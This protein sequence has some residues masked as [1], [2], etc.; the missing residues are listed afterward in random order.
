MSET[1]SPELGTGEE[2]VP[3]VGEQ[4]HLPGPSIM[5]LVLAVGITMS[6]IGITLSPKILVPLGLVISI[7]TIVRW[8]RSTRSE[9]A[10]LPPVH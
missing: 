5:P 8:V 9:I 2:P 3:P 4:I 6:V 10:E 1:A 7:V